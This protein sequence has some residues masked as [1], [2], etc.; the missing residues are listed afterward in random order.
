MKKFLN[1]AWLAK[2]SAIF[3]KYRLA[4]KWN[5]VQKKKH[6]ANF[7]DYSF[8]IGLK[9]ETI[10]KIANKIQQFPAEII[11]KTKSKT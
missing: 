9:Y 1:S 3:S 4:K 7:S 6:C 8:L 11:Q 2:S 5:T 10:T